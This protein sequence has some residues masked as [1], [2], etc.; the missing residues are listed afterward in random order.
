MMRRE[1][2][3]IIGSC[4]SSTRTNRNTATKPK[5]QQAAGSARAYICVWQVRDTGALLRPSHGT[6]E[7]QPRGEHDCWGGAL[8]GDKASCIISSATIWPPRNT[9]NEGFVFEPAFLLLNTKKHKPQAPK[10]IV[11]TYR[12]HS[13]R[14]FNRPCTEQQSTYSSTFV[15]TRVRQRKQAGMKEQVRY[16]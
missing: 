9:N 7:Y 1:D 15:S 14:A 10:A 3:A 8:L 6:G 16:C 5:Q 13:R 12:K 2:K 11:S 4:S